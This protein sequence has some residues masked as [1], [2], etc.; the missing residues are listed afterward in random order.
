MSIFAFGLYLVGLG[1]GLL[2]APDTM[3]ALFRQPPTHEP[4]LRVVGIISIVLGL[5][6]ASA[7]RSGT[8]AFFR[9]TL[10]GRPVAAA[11]LFGLV[12]LAIAPRF[13]L[14]LAGLDLFGVAWTY[15]AL[16]STSSRG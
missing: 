6:Y 16:R 2:L 3:L 8:T 10:W 11:L 13:V 15:W 12:A 14:L 1:A 7:A 4:W 9:W 5:Y